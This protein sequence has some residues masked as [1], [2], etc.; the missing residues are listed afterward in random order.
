MLVALALAGGVVALGLRPATGLG[1]FVSS[2][3]PDYRATMT[4]ARRFGGDA[5]VV[6]VREPLQQLVARDLKR[7]SALE[8][9][10]AGERLA[11]DRRL[12][13]LLPGAGGPYGGSS[14]PCAAL[15]RERPATAVYGPGT[16]LNRAVAAV[17]GQLLRTGA[18]AR[19]AVTNAEAAAR[20][21][22]RQRGL[23]P[24]QMTA[25]ARTAGQLEAQRIVGGLGALALA[26]GADG[27]PSI[28]DPAF[29][30]R[31]VF[32][33]AANGSGTV[34][35]RFSYVF[36]NGAAAVIEVRLRASLSAARES[37]AIRLIR[38]AVRMPQF[39]LGSGGSYLVSGEPVLLSD[40]ASLLTR[41]I[42]PLLIVAAV[43]MAAVLALAFGGPLSL[44]PLALALA[45]AAIA[46]GLLE[47][48]GGT[49]TL[50]SLAGVPILIGLAVDY[51]IQFQ[52]RLRERADAAS[53]A[54]PIAA[55][56]LATGAGFV[57]LLLSPVPMVR[58]FGALLVVGIAVALAC[59]FTVVPAAL[60]LRRPRR[61]R[62]I[63]WLMPSVRGAGE[64]LATPLRFTPSLRSILAGLARRPG[65]VLVLGLV[66][67]AAGWVLDAHTPVQADVT[68]LVPAGMPALRNLEALE[69]ATGSSGEIDVLVSARDVTA[70]G[71]VS[72]MAGYERALLRHFGFAG[73]RGCAA[74]TVCPI[75]SLPDLVAPASGSSRAAPGPTQGSIDAL[76]SALPSYF[77]SAVITADRRY[78]VLAFGIRLMPLAQ[79]R[80]VVGYMRAH[81]RPPPGVHASLAGL[82][83][84]A[85]D[86]DG[87]LS[88]PSRR[89]ET[90]LAGLLAVSFALLVALR[91]VRRALVPLIPIVLASGWSALV[92]FATGL[93]LNPLSATLGALVIA[94]STEFSVLLAERAREERLSGGS[95]VEALERAYRSTGRAVLA[96]GATAIA[97]F[98]VLLVSSIAMLRDFGLVTVVDLAVSLAGVL[99]T[100]PAALAVAESAA[101]AGGF[102]A[103]AG[104]V[105]AR[106]QTQ[107]A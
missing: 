100:L 59:T 92:L 106:E 63:E 57:A 37:Q 29:L 40:L 12:Q 23:S 44:L 25:A 14:G 71:A 46:F 31:I 61:S 27:V 56:A 20:A 98:A 104:S 79:Q 42:A 94:I 33:T 83:V 34:N 48:A 52:S 95:F 69:R 67:A 32:A 30:D 45:G 65:R 107:V 55:A 47:L 3:T 9:C 11:W 21:L 74:A 22:A 75:V 86:A 96:S 15:M 89:L 50:A 54:R 8:A 70:R 105:A 26:L 36:P 51:A 41:S 38:A 64:L 81:L 39:A 87:A 58:G 28:D 97:G 10:L 82:P 4:D 16:F 73:A 24:R 88:S 77:S 91:S 17:N 99:I 90:V 19:R 103:R 80:R 101:A 76:L 68:K 13:A 84:L 2:S 43:V 7:V 1:T 66:A 5:V 53:A 49:L 60:V 18:A 93:P 78:A 102:R 85:A 62:P 35:P 6:L 72:W